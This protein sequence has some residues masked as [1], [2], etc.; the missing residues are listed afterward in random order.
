[1]KI[2]HNPRCRKSREALNYLQ[3]KGISIE[4]IDYMKNPISKEEL[5]HVLH[6]LDY[7]AENLLRKN[8]AIYKEKF[9]GLEL[10]EEEW[11]EAMI[12]H[13]KLM[14]RPIVVD[15]DNAV[16]ARPLEKIQEIL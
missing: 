5:T 6:L 4:V 10:T 11:I 15:K 14:E 16:V 3:D 7:K 2:Y 9:K 13:P 8:E 12:E 1:M